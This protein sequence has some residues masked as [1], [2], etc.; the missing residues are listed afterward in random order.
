MGLTSNLD[1]YFESFIAENAYIMRYTDGDNIVLESLEIFG[2]L[3]TSRF[4]VPGSYAFS[5][6]ARESKK[7]LKSLL[8]EL[9]VS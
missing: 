9:L 5:L 2:F 8:Y 6:N 1:Y 4:V 7:S 3:G